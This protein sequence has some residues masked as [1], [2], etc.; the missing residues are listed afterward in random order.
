L[1]QLRTNLKPKHE[2]GVGTPF[3]HVPVPLHPWS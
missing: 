3:P 2:K 1:K